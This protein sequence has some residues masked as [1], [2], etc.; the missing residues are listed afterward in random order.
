MAKQTQVHPAAT[1][2][3]TSHQRVTARDADNAQRDATAERTIAARPFPERRFKLT[4]TSDKEPR[5]TE[6]KRVRAKALENGFYDG[7]RIRAGSYFDVIEGHEGSWFEVV[8]PL[9]RD[10]KGG[11]GGRKRGDQ[12]VGTLVDDLKAQPDVNDNLDGQGRKIGETTDALEQLPQDQ[13]PDPETAGL[14]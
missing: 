7:A 3:R 1:A 11:K 4:D 2:A 6:G 14:A 12:P 8:D 10:G 5:T 13:Q 9:D